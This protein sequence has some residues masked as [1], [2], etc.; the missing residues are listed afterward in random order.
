M[1]IPDWLLGIFLIFLVVA[2]GVATCQPILPI[3]HRIALDRIGDHYFEMMVRNASVDGIGL[4][5]E[6]NT[7][8]NLELVT[9]G[10]SVQT[11][12]ASQKC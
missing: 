3:F 6:Q 4:T 9:K 1:G 2:V 10:F 8:L 5:D 11:I 7:T 12:S